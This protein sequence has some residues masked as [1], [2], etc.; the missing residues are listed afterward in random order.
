MVK[1][2]LVV[3]AAAAFY[4]AHAFAAVVSVEAAVSV[5]AAQLRAV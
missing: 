4:G 1:F 2:V 3:A 5:K